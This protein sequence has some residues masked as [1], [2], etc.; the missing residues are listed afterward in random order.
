MKN[1]KNIVITSNPFGFGP[2]GKAV[3]IIKLILSDRTFK[4]YNIYFLGSGI[5]LEI[6]ESDFVS[7]GLKVIKIDE[8]S[9]NELERFLRNLKGQT[10]CIGFQNRFI[11]IVAKKLKIE[12]YFVDGLAWFWKKTPD[13][14]FTANKVYWT[15]FLNIYFGDKKVPQN[16]KLIGT[17]HS[18]IKRKYKYG[19]RKFLLVSLGGAKN[20]LRGG[21]QKNYLK[22][23]V[24]V[25]DKICKD[26]LMKIEITSGAD[27]TKFM[28]NYNLHKTKNK[29]LIFKNYPHNKMMQRFSVAYHHFSVGGQTSSMEALSSKTPTSFFLPSNFAQVEFQEYLKKYINTDLYYG[30]DFFI[31]L[32][33]KKK[34]DEKSYIKIIDKL[35]ERLF[36]NEDFVK[37]CENRCLYTMS[38]NMG[39]IFRIFAGMNKGGGKEIIQDIKKYFK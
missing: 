18:T 26:L 17:L 38:K 9:K 33:N 13:S 31:R 15:N 12:C 21:L 30:W 35:S 4:G 10:L 37:K 5:C 32:D 11:P 23:V 27:A 2:T 3:E 28:S 19:D 20:P 6:L 7:K 36:N 14:H 8:R 39:E 29:N 24:N 34:L 22:L 1:T 25:F 16:V